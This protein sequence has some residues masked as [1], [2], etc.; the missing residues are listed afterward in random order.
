MIETDLNLIGC[1]AVEDRLKEGIETLSKAGLK[2]CVLIMVRCMESV[3]YLPRSR[4]SGILLSRLLVLGVE[5]ISL[6]RFIVL[7]VVRTYVN[8]YDLLNFNR[9]FYSKCFDI[10]IKCFRSYLDQ[11][12]Q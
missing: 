1:T 10:Q 6:C 3:K 2:I 7:V 9:P 11:G 8:M 4:V 5:S 12:K